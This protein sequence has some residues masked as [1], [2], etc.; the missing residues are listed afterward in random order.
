MEQRIIKKYPN[1]RLYDTEE[2]KY[3][4]LAHLRQLIQDGVEF[5]VTDSQS[6]KDITRSILIQIITEQEAGN[7]AEGVALVNPSQ[8]R[9]AD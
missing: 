9:N 2:S 8:H 6:G 3:V 1:R 4:T 5:K 7:E